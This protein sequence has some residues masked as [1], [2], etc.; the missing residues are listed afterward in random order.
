MPQSFRRGIATGEL[1]QVTGDLG[2][3][4][5]TKSPM[6]M[7]YRKLPKTASLPVT[8][9]AFVLTGFLCLNE[10]VRTPNVEKRRLNYAVRFLVDYGFS[11]HRNLTLNLS[12]R[13]E[14]ICLKH[15]VRQLPHTASFDLL[16]KR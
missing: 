6:K 12:R 14:A 2:D 4:V 9:H 13:C 8:R 1:A 15:R 10:R 3:A 7:L 11:W 16:H 5:S